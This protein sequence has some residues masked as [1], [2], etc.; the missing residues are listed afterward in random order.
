MNVRTFTGQNEQEVRK[1][2]ISTF[3]RDAVILSTRT[4]SR[5]G[6]WGLMGRSVIEIE[7]C[8]GRDLS[9][10]RRGAKFRAPAARSRRQRRLPQAPPWNPAP[11]AILR[12]AIPEAGGRSW[13]A[14]GGSQCRT[15]PRAAGAYRLLIEGKWPEL[16]G[17]RQADQRQVSR[18]LRA[19]ALRMFAQVWK[20]CCRPAG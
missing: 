11:G 13:P 5:G 15:F 4:V 9:R 20:G 16:A 18:E 1:A 19:G 7:A 3:G 8:G 12:T 14:R 2:I 10:V 6:I 17:H